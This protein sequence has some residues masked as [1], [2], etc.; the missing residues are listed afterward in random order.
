MKTWKN[1][2]AFN[3]NWDQVVS[4]E[5]KKY[6]NLKINATVTDVDIIDRRITKDGTLTTLRILTTKWPFGSWALKILG[7]S[8]VC[9]VRE[10]SHVDP[11]LKQMTITTNNLTYSSI[12]NVTETISYGIHPEIKNCTLIKHSIIVKMNGKI[13]F[14]TQIENL[15][16]NMTISNSIKAL[17]AVEEAFNT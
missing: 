1:E 5:F 15:I 13:P 3:Y 17:K 2:K 7:G 16:L 6:P 12:S 14:S 10:Y 8:N 9:H 4:A 11:T